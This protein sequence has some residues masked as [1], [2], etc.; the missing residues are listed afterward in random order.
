MSDPSTDLP[1]RR[2]FITGLGPVSA[3]GLGVD[4]LWAGLSGGR[5]A[6]APIR[7]FDASEFDCAIAGEVPEDFKVRDFVPKSYRKATKVMAR[8]IELAVAA[9][10]LAVQDAGITTPGSD[11]DG[12]RSY[13]SP[14]MGVHIG[15]GLIA[16]EENELTYALDAARAEDGSFDI[17]KWGSEGM[18]QL[19]PLWLLKYLPNMLAAHVT[20]IHDAQGPSNTITCNEA[21]A[22]LSLG[23]SLRVIQRGQADA[24]L[25]GGADSKMT[26]M[27]LLRQVLAGRC[28]T[29]DKDA[30]EKAVRPFCQTAAGTA[31]GEGGAVLV[32][33]SV[34]TFERR[35]G[36]KAYA[37]VVGFGAAQS[38]NPETKNL[39]PDA[40]GKAFASAMRKALNDAG[41]TPDDIGLVVPFGLGHSGSDGPEAKAIKAVFGGRAA[42]VPLACPKA[43]VGS[44]SAGASGID[45]SLA[46]KALAEQQIPDTIS[47]T[48][49]IEGLNITR[50]GT[51]T[52]SFDHALVIASGLGGQTAACVLKK[53]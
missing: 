20:I 12:E 41:V 9:A 2:V 37:E 29:T 42:D 44:C 50:G 52:A 1:R 46:A 36:E 8:D 26:P 49:P 27:A 38:L 10:H 43:N 23:E 14:R 51:Q 40:E 45:L 34:E 48:D 31:L 5:S 21:S 28:N 4:A 19:T 35:G 18:S 15:A 53:V 24:C 39:L 17:N 11:P 22:M 13:A 7:Q 16:T 30:P 25:S 32:L 33:E 47:T 6:L 3:L